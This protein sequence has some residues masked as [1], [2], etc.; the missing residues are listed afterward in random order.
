M[1]STPRNRYNRPVT[2]RAPA[3]VASKPRVFLCRSGKTKRR[4][5]R[6][7]RDRRNG[8]VRFKTRPKEWKRGR[9]SGLLCE[10]TTVLKRSR[11]PLRR[12]WS[13]VPPALLYCVPS[14]L[15][16][17]RPNQL[18]RRCRAGNRVE[19]SANPRSGWRSDRGEIG[20]RSSRRDSLPAQKGWDKAAIELRFSIPL[21]RWPYRSREKSR[22][23]ET[24]L[25]F[26]CV[27]TS[28]TD[29]SRR[30]LPKRFP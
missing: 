5:E 8:N 17:V 28:G 25:K 7:G 16:Q 4:R 9:I 23:F 12:H 21:F 22:V 6:L 29:K 26:L 13:R 2:T 24:G 1:K 18:F 19:G 10:Q 3:A 11:R 15:R 27:G 30:K 14:G 20:R